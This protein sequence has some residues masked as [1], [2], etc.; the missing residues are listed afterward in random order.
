MALDFLKVLFTYGIAIL[1]ILGGGVILW[2]TRDVP[3]ADNLQLVISGFMGIAINWVFGEYTGSRTARQ[4][5]RALLQTAPSAP[6]NGGT[7]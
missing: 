2:Q 6:N 1:V 5:T 4:T 3:S 7:K